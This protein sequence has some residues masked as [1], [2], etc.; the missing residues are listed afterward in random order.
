MKFS[1]FFTVAAIAAFASADSTSDGV[2][3][4][5]VTTT[6]QSTTSMVSTVKT[7]STPYTTSTIA[8]LSTKSI[9]SQA[10]TTTHEISTYVGAAV[11]GSVAGMGAIMGAAAF[12]LL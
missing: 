2:T 1:T 11:K 8:T 5:D 4:V 10:N 12:A 3:Y 7:T 9:S 6:P